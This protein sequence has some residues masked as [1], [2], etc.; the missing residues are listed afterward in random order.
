M[1]LV[2]STAG[3]GTFD[4][5]VTRRAPWIN[6]AIAIGFVLLMLQAAIVVRARPGELIT[7]VVGMADILRRATP[8]NFSILGQALWPTLET[9]DTALFGTVAAVIMAMPLARGNGRPL[10]NSPACWSRPKIR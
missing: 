10:P 8:P 9:F 7:G 4:P 2:T 5:A 6:A 1:K 3:A